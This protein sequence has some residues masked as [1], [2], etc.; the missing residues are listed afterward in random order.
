MRPFACNVSF[1]SLCCFIACASS[2]TLE[3][4]GAAKPTPSA[5]HP[6]GDARAPTPPVVPTGGEQA[7][8]V[9]VDADTPMSTP[10]G[11]TYIA[12]KGWTVTAS[13]GVTRLEDPNREVSMWFVERKEADGVAAI[14]AA[15]EQ[16]K[17]GFRRTLMLTT[18]RPGRNGWDASLAAFYETT[19]AEGRRVVA[20]A[21]RK[22]DTWFVALFDGTIEGW[23]RRLPQAEIARSS[24]RAKGVV[25]ESFAGRRA[26]VLDADRLGQF[27]AFVE[28]GRKALQIPGLAVAIVQG[29][30][31]VYEKGFGTREL[32]KD[33]PV[34]PNTMFQIASMT[35]PLT[36]LMIAS[37]VDDGKF[38][39]DTKVTTLVPSFAL[40]DAALTSKLTMRNILCACTGIPYDNL[41]LV[42]E[43]RGVSA[44]GTLARMAELHPTT[45]YGETFQY[46]NAMIAAAGYI[47]AHA[48]E[49]K[50]AMAA[51][52]HAAMQARV[53]AP[54][55]MKN[56]TFDSRVVARSEHAAEHNRDAHLE[57]ARLPAGSAAWTVPMDP[58][59]GAWS[60]VHDMAQ[61]L[62]M[63][64]AK[65]KTPKGKQLVTEA[66]LLARR[67][68]QARAAEKYSYGLA[69][70]VETYRDVRIYGHSGGLIGASS[71][72]FFLPDQDVG[73]VML[74]NSGFPSPLA[75]T[76]FRRKLL[77]VLFDGRDEAREDLEVSL[78][79]MRAW[80]EEENPKFDFAPAR[81]FVEPF[82][83]SYTNP[84]YGRIG[85]SFDAKAGAVLDA[86][87][88]ASSL[89]KKT[90]ED[91]TEKLVVT[92]PGW[93]GWIEFV[94]EEKEGKVTLW[95]Q[96]DQ[97]KV[98]FERVSGRR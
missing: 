79:E 86:G 65:G 45:G 13:A 4:G 33:A 54:L 69:L 38:S 17:P 39:W 70:E 14:T 29:G 15:W 58:G 73:A 28:A 68:P 49:P 60:T 42:F 32:G 26:H 55:G 77:E 63:E 51:A 83:G 82:I 57:M 52:Y 34:T 97:R 6:S 37:L 35:K 36:S 18:P 56:T 61:V 25:E 87:E 19:V 71:Y 48:A 93:M 22:G 53:F 94:R 84:L 9:T 31:V 16:V 27:D 43:S 47:A 11:S 24:F 44:E 92:S 78:Q 2:P 23:G 59:A 21:T 62:L 76:H 67:E 95:F 80:R 75:Y 10:S 20:H 96:D 89:S 90:E 98:V 85:I 64:L 30:G 81:A 40:G 41:G 91:G 12:P 74:T 50:R 72:M 7:K 5:A 8:A 3:H 1:L 46:S 66:N 88:W